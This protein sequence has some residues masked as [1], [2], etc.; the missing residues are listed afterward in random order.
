MKKIFCYLALALNPMTA[1]TIQGIVI[2]ESDNSPLIGANIL[3]SNLEIGSTTDINGEFIFSNINK[4]QFN[5]E[6]SMIGYDKYQKLSLIH[7]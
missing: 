1:A 7:I 5:L 6:I 2:D 3:L 4:R